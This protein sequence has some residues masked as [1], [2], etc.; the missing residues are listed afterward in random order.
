MRVEICWAQAYFEERPNFGRRDL[1]LGNTQQLVRKQHAE[2][3][4]RTT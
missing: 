3:E 1:I 2:K 4:G